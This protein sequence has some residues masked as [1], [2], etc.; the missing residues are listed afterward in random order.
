MNEIIQHNLK[1]MIGCKEGEMQKLL[2]RESIGG[3]AGSFRGV[4]CAAT[5]FFYDKNTGEIK[6]FENWQNVPHDIK[7]SSPEGTFRI[8]M[9]KKKKIINC[10]LSKD[11]AE[12]AK[13]NIEETVEE[14]NKMQKE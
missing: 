7:N 11:V 13:K 9:T 14:Y 4:S 10:Y 5:N 2:F 8:V 3:N 1:K 6:Y 12:E